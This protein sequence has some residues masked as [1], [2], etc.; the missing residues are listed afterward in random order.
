M[1][2]LI[3]GASG[4]IGSHVLKALLKSNHSVTTCM[5]HSE[6]TE[7]CKVF[8]VDYIQMQHVRDWLPLLQNMDVVINC[9]GIIAESPIVNFNVMHHL[10]P[11]ALFKACQQHS[12]KKVIQISSLGANDSAIVPYHKTKKLADDYL[13]QSTLD[14]LIIKPS[15]IY[16]EGGESY[17]F[18]KKLS[19]LPLIPLIGGGQQMIQPVHIGVLVNVITTYL[20]SSIKGQKIIDVVG[21]KAISYQHWMQSLRTK[22]TKIRFLSI[23]FKL[24]MFIAKIAN[25]FGAKLLSP[26]NLTML[27]QNNTADVKPLQNFL[28]GR[29]S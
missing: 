28:N 2:I 9:V 22:N 7:T 29:K 20:K 23:P 4:F 18:F 15:L 17:R 21:P 25:L 16:G 19:N 24:M 6:I 14:Y 26:D 5:H 3:T 8:K 10:T 11:I 1:N 12:I 13:I 27:K